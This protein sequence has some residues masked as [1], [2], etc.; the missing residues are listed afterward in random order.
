MTADPGPLRQQGKPH[1]RRARPSVASRDLLSRYQAA[2]R[3]DLDM[4]LRALRSD[5]LSL[6][7]RDKYWGLAIKLGRELGNEVEVK[8]PAKEPTKLA[9]RGPA[10]VNF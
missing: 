6:A 7:E 9:P 1:V 2:M 10:A 3:T 4:V 8:P 5:T